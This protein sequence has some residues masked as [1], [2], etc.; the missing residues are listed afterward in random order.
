MQQ[1]Y[2]SCTVGHGPRIKSSH[3]RNMV[4]VEKFRKDPNRPVGPNN[5]LVKTC[6]DCRE[7][8]R[9]K[10]RQNTKLK[11]DK[12]L[13]QQ[14]LIAEGKSKFGYC[15]S[16][17]HG[18]S[19]KSEY[20]REEIPVDMLRK[21]PGDPKSEL[22]LQCSDCRSSNAEDLNNWKHEKREESASKG[23]FR[24]YHCHKEVGDESR[25]LNLD[26]TP[27]VHCLNC[28]DAQNDRNGRRLLYVN[29]L[30]LEFMEKQQ[31]S[32]YNCKCLFLKPGENSLISS[33]IETYEIDGIRKFSLG[34]AEYPVSELL[35][36][37]N[38]HLLELC[39]LQFDHLPEDEQRV[40]GIL[41]DDEAYIPKRYN[42][43]HPMSMSAKRLESLKCQ[44]SCIMCHVKDTFRRLTDEDGNRRGYITRLHRQKLEYV[45]S[46]KRCGCSSCGYKNDE[47]P[48][49]FDCDHLDPANKIANI[50]ILVADG[51]C[52]MEMFIEE[53]RKC[54]IL[55]KQCHI[56]HSRNQTLRGETRLVV[57]R[58]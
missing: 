2:A 14:K 42:V 10:G 39:V 18:S 44:L 24:C 22:Y 20:A 28:K 9:N 8:K 7:Y 3:P 30:K 19:V 33:R 1:Q 47:F 21:I 52:S 56:I 51:N 50:A 13:E 34:G 36:S 40:R 4:P 53:C 55:C 26:G 43:S 5:P 32:C 45:N 16:K 54:R 27:S 58:K 29:E 48:E 23:L 35:S 37:E 49:L 41:E 25:A 11:K 31:S 15:A 57:N 6:S 46:L 38:N 17:Y 12:A